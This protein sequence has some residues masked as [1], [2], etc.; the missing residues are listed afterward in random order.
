MRIERPDDVKAVADHL[1]LCL[2]IKRI[3]MRSVEEQ[4]GMGEG[5]LGQ[6]LRGNLDLKVKHVMAVLAAIGMGPDEFFSS[7]YGSPSPAAFVQPAFSGPPRF[8]LGGMPA[9]RPGE[10]VPGVSEE[11]LDRAIRESLARLGYTPGQAA[12]EEERESPRQ[13]RKYKRGR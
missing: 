7:L 4:L 3:T 5:Y 13:G 2:Q 9:R 8:D 12:T 1:R 6:L 10:I 11:R